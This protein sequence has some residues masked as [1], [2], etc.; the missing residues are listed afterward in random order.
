MAPIAPLLLL[1]S[2]HRAW[3]G[4][5]EWTEVVPASPLLQRQ[6]HM[7][8]LTGSS[9]VWIFGGDSSNGTEKNDLWNIDTQAASPEWTEV[10]ALGSIPLRRQQSS[11]VLTTSSKLWIF[12]GVYDGPSGPP[13]SDMWNIDLSLAMDL[14][15][16]VWS[17]VFTSGPAAHYGHSAVISASGKMWIFGG[18]DASV[19]GRNDLWCVDTTASSPAWQQVL[20]SGNTPP[21]R[22]DHSAVMTATGT[23]FVFAGRMDLEHFNDLWS[24]DLEAGSSGVLYSC[25]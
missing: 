13:L 14:P 3:A 6:Y 9:K 15:L 23:M 11:A 24:I 18:M 5:P 2:A 12:G 21:A 8:A 7:T 25:L 16:A 17:R 4:T 10:A 22:A 20:V 1:L 19:G